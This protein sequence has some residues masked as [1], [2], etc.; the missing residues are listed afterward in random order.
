MTNVHYNRRL[1]NASQLAL[2]I[3]FTASVAFGQQDRATLTGKLSD[4]SGATI[5]GVAVTITNLATNSSYESKSNG[6]GTYSVPNLPIG[7][8]RLV[9]QRTGFKRLT[10][11]PITIVAA[12]IARIDLEMQVGAVTDSVEVRGQSPMLQTDTPEVSTVLNSRELAGLPLSFAGGRYAED[13]AYKLTPGVSG[14]NWESRI[15]GSAA[16]SKAVVLD[17]SDAT[18]YIGGQFGESTPSLEAFAEFKVQTSGMSAEYGRTGGGVFNFV[19]KSG[20]NQIHGS[21]LGLL[22]NEWM[23]AN[24]FV[25]NYYGKPRQR[26]RRNDLGGSVGGPVYVPK[27]YNGKDQT[28]FYVAYERYKESYAGGGSPTVTVPLDE[29]WNG[30]LGRLLT[31]QVIGIDALGR[32]IHKGAIYNPASTRS[33]NG[34]MVRDPFPGN[35][36]PQSQISGPA[37]NLGAIFKAHYSPTIKGPDGLV[38]LLNNS[39]FPVSNQAGFTQNQFS[40]KIDHYL[41]VAH[42]LN[43]SFAY[44]DRPRSLLDQGGV[45]DFSD[46]SGGP[47]SRSRLQWVRSWYGRAA[48]DWTLSSSILNHLQL[49]FNRQ[50]NPSLSAHLNENG[51]AALGLQGLSK[52]YNYPEINFG[53]TNYLVNY[54]TLGYQTNDFG[55]GQSFQIIDTVTWIK[56]RHSIRAGVDWRRSYLRWR[57]D[58]GPAEIN[59]NQAQTGLQG[60]NQTGNGFASMLLGDAATA[61]VPT[62]TP[63]GSKFLNF[64]LFL[65]DDFKINSRLTLNLG[66]RWDYQPLPVE[67]YN[68]L[69][70]FN[71]SL[72]DPVWGL[73]GSLEF[74]SPGHRTFAPNHYRDFSPRIGFA[75]QVTGKTVVRG[76]Y[77][78]FYLA[79]NGNGWSGVP[80]G[81]TAGFGQ[82]NRVSPKIDYE[83]AWNWSS[84]YP[85]AVNNLPQNPSL[86]SGS[87]GVWGI[88]SY[89][90]DAGK[91]GY[92]QQWN[93]N[94]QR[95]LPS[96]MIFDIGYV[97][98]KSTGIQANELR[99]VNQLDPKHLM[100]GDALGAGV[101]SQAD[102]PPSV[103]AA[104]GRY[105]FGNTGIWVPA[106]QTLLPYPQMMAWNEIKSA[107]TPLGFSTY[108]ALQAQLNKRFSEGLSFASNY[109]FS[110]SIDNVH[111][112]FGDTWGANGGRPANYYNLALDKSISD[113]DRT[114]AF[115]ISVSYDLPFG[116]RRRFG[117]AA[118]NA[119]VLALSGWTVQYIGN[120]NSG[121]PLGIQGS[122]TSNSNFAANS[123]FAVNANGQPLSTGW[124]SSRIDVSR[125]NQPNA[126]N[127]Y[128]NTSVFVDPITIGRYQRGNTSFKL[129]QLRGP[130]EL[131]DQF[132][133]QKQFHP[134][135]SLRI[136]FRADFL[137]AF[138][139][140]LWGNI[141]TNAA[142]P[143]FG[144]VTGASDWFSPRKIQFGVRA[145]F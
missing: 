43:G 27:F 31:N 3:V 143:I 117:S 130:W 138:N 123:G 108:H 104:G 23:D 38:S 105:P 26:D 111:S 6:D 35:L 44:T 101:T 124:D 42:K 92:A 28:F 47:L 66:V 139:R 145:D 90:P 75:Y 18:I 19:M 50:R 1:R 40:A 57:T 77:G 20:T 51:V 126:S 69:S 134:L 115:K 74:A 46:P 9:F 37:R 119:T 125:I 22:H 12:Q 82:E 142:S 60:F 7:D 95:E 29:F 59:F 116:N 41:S 25:N 49:G 122:G 81:Q 110:K 45:W 64:A 63:T 10:R 96:Q 88:V 73:P 133:L 15:N 55:A 93:L 141:E 17:G 8:Y 21:A 48:Y 67:H 13:F 84:P 129:S 34:Q 65:Q 99:R 89:D 30:N 32:D 14:N 86:A 102:V 71:P 103:A 132:S 140:T 114:H 79:R 87:P 83:A 144:Q 136:Q 62:A 91:N 52:T 98:S 97:G 5:S 39:T 127:M 78:I 76:A 54:P 94:I 56:N 112:A 58:N 121:W 109:T 2:R 85:G 61:S 107:S 68:R 131:T 120:Y 33:V 53:N 137:N 118:H 16:F 100:L 128:I 80:W 135:E 70:N 11:E 106:Y 4:A 24:S 36:I 113:A 72:T